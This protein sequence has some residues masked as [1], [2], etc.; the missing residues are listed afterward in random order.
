MDSTPGNH[1]THTQSVIFPSNSSWTIY[2]RHGPHIYAQP[3]FITYPLFVPIYIQGTILLEIGVDDA[4]NGFITSST[5]SPKF[6]SRVLKILTSITADPKYDFAGEYRSLPFNGCRVFISRVANGPLQGDMESLMEWGNGWE[7]STRSL[8]VLRNFWG[9]SAAQMP[10]VLPLSSLTL[11]AWLHDTV[12]LVETASEPGRL[13]AFKTNC[14][15]KSLYQ[16]IH[17]LLTLPPH[18]NIL[19]RPPYLITKHTEYSRLNPLDTASRYCTEPTQ[20]IIGF[21]TPYHPGGTLKTHISLSPEPPWHHCARWAHQLTSALH[22]IFAHGGSPGMYTSLKMDN[23]IL[24]TQGNLVLIDFELAGTWIQYTPAEVLHAPPTRVFRSS[25]G[26]RYRLAETPLPGEYCST[27]TP[28]PCTV[29]RNASKA[30]CYRL[31]GEVINYRFSRTNILSPLKENSECGRWEPRKIAFWSSASPA[32][33]EAAMVWMLGCCLWCIL[34]ARSCLS[35]L[36]AEWFPVLTPM[37]KRAKN[38]V[39]K[40][41][42][43]VVERALKLDRR[44]CLAEMMEI[45]E[46]WAMDTSMQFEDSTDGGSP[47][48]RPL[49]PSKNVPNVDPKKQKVN[50]GTGS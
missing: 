20:P 8:V 40:D 28:H 42:L 15:A 12:T 50:L 45:V 4:P 33:V 36:G 6:Y 19:G 25:A 16:E 38:T 30:E 29:P 17:T 41:V 26:P 18:P 3:S 21:L 7:A 24:D 13:W 14:S 39:P 2:G 44:P 47:N 48:K 1:S 32:Q 22:H 46:K 23:I 27:C 35:E 49:S 11:C 10:D 31:H 9:L 5:L 34:E 43:T 37:W